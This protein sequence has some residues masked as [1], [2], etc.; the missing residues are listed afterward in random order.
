MI[1]PL[2]TAALLS[3]TTLPAQAAQHCAARD[4]VIARLDTGYG[5]TRQSWGLAANNS[6]IEVYASD[7][8][9]TWTILVTT[10]Q[11]VSCILASGQ[12]Y[13]NMD[14]PVTPAKGEAL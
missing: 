9:G 3:A 7:E 12:A 8:T 13:E 5:E 10:A 14:T 4:H 6:V 2:L 1:R 11:G